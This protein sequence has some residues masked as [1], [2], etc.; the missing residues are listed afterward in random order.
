MHNQRAGSR[1]TTD[2]PGRQHPSCPTLGAPS[3]ADCWLG[4]PS[5]CLRSD[6]V[7]AVQ[8]PGIASATR[9]AITDALLRMEPTLVTHGVILP[10]I[11]ADA[12][13]SAKLPEASWNTRQRWYER[14]AYLIGS[15][16]SG[17]PLAG[18]LLDR[19]LFQYTG[20]W[21][22]ARAIRA[23]GAIADAL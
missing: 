7:L 1:T 9:W 5:L 16:N 6:T 21:L 10:F 13:I 22:K 8:Q 17:D 20:V 3:P 19:C 23:T 4:S 15:I 14:V 12:A 18:A 11:D 2:R